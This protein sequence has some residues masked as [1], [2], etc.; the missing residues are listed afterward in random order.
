VGESGDPLETA[1]DNLTVNVGGDVNIHSIHDVTIGASGDVAIANQGDLTVADL[2]ADGNAAEDRDVTLTAGGDLTVNDTITGGSAEINTLDGDVSGSDGKPLDLDVD[3]LSGTITGDAAI[4]SQGDLTVDDLTVTGELDLTVNG[5]L[6]GG[7]AA[8]GTANITAGTASITADGNVG[9]SGD[10]LETAVD[11]LTVNVGGDV[12]IHSI[13]DVTIDNIIG[14]DIDISVDGEVYAGEGPVHIEGD[15]LDISAIGSIGTKKRPLVVSI[16]GRVRD[17]TQYGVIYLKNIYEEPV[18]LAGWADMVFRSD[19][20]PAVVRIEEYFLEE[21]GDGIV[22]KSR[23]GDG[24]I[25]LRD[26]ADELLRGGRILGIL[27]LTDDGRALTNEFRYLLL[28]A[29]QR[30]LMLSLGYR[31]VVLRIGGLALVIDLTALDAEGDYLFALD[32]AGN[33]GLLS[34]GVIATLA[35]NGQELVFWN[36]RNEMSGP[37]AEA[38]GQAVTLL[39]ADDAADL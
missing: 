23:F 10:P 7:D 26:A 37:G 5:D 16:S 13:H 39:T 34:D 29:G 38:L 31:W 2:N 14:E 21:A 25:V 3:N 4:T 12:N 35:Y 19:M 17:D 1:V 36:D 24:K 33:S 20:S 11:N 30:A 6:T 18:P 28:T 15:S 9:E 32:P 22:L 27:A 8:P